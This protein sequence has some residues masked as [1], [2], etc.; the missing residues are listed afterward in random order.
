MT[1]EVKRT[2]RVELVSPLPGLTPDSPLQIWACERLGPDGEETGR[3]ES[4]SRQFARYDLAWLWWRWSR[5]PDVAERARFRRRG[6][7]PGVTAM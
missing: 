7:E 6:R 2:H 1:A 3:V 5:W 4:W